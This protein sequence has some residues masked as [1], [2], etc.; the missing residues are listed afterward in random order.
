MT[1]SDLTEGVSIDADIRDYFLGS[2]TEEDAITLNNLRQ[3]VKVK[4]GEIGEDHLTRIVELAFSCGAAFAVK[5][6]GRVVVV[7]DASV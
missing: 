5:N 6:P 3:I 1:T 2:I 7:E 4:A